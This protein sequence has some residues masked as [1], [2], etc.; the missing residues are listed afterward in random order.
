MDEKTFPKALF[1]R[2]DRN[3]DDAYMDQLK[4]FI[5]C[6]NRDDAVE[7]D[8]AHTFV[9]EYHLQS[10]KKLKKSVVEAN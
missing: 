4:D 10:V 9:A 8:E 6:G 3:A 1:V 2:H 5:A 7:D